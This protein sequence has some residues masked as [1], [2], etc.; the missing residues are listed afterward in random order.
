ML[1]FKKEYFQ[2]ET[3]RHLYPTTLNISKCEVYGCKE[4]EAFVYKIPNDR[5]ASNAGNIDFSLY[6]NGVWSDYT[7]I[8]IVEKLPYFQPSVNFNKLGD[9]TASN[10]NKLKDEIKKHIVD[11]ETAITESYVF[12]D[13]GSAGQNNLPYLPEGCVWFRDPIIKDVIALPISDLYGK[14]NQMV[15]EIRNAIKDL[16]NQDISDETKKLL[17]KLR[18]ETD[19]LLEELNQA[20]A[21]LPNR[22][23]AIEKDVADFK[24]ENET[25]HNELKDEIRT[26]RTENIPAE[27]LVD[28][29][30]SAKKLKTATDEDKIKLVNLSDEV[31]KAMA[32]N[33]P[34]SPTLEKDSV[35]REYIA[36]EAVN[37]SK[38][39]NS[40]YHTEYD[41]KKES[42]WNSLGFKL[43]NA[44][45]LN[46]SNVEFSFVTSYDETKNKPL[47]FSMSDNANIPSGIV[48]EKKIEKLQNWLFKYL[49][50]ANNVTH[51]GIITFGFGYDQPQK[52]NLSG[53]YY[54]FL[55]EVDGKPIEF[56]SAETPEVMNI[57]KVD[58]KAISYETLINEIYARPFSINDFSEREK[59]LLTGYS[60]L[61]NYK[62]IIKKFESFASFKKA[63]IMYDKILYPGVYRI[64]N[65]YKG[66]DKIRIYTLSNFNSKKIKEVIE[67]NSEN[68]LFLLK[69]TSFI[70]IQIIQNNTAGNH[71][72][73]SK[74]E[75]YTCKFI[76]TETIYDVEDILDM[77]NIG[78]YTCMFNI[79]CIEIYPLK[80]EA[81]ILKLNKKILKLN[82]T[83]GK[84][85]ARN[86]STTPNKNLEEVYNI[87]DIKTVEF[88]ENLEILATSNTLIKNNKI[89]YKPYQAIDE[90]KIKLKFKLSVIESK[91]ILKN[92]DGEFTD[93]TFVVDFSKKE[94]GLT[95]K[96]ND[97]K[98]EKLV[99]ISGINF[100]TIDTYM[101]DFYRTGLFMCIN[102]Y[103]LKSG[104]QFEHKVPRLR[105]H[106][107]IGIEIGDGKIELSNIRFLT[108][109]NQGT[110]AIFIGDSITEGLG[111]KTTDISKRWCSLLR[112]SYFNGNALCCGI[113]NGTTNNVKQVLDNIEYYC[114]YIKYYFVMI[115]TN[116]RSTG[117]VT[118]W[119]TQ[120]VEIYNKIK[121]FGGIPII[122]VPPLARADSE[123]ILQMRD[124]ILENG[125]DTIRM[126]IATSTGDG[127]TFDTSLST[128][129]VH[130]NVNGN[131]KMYERALIDLKKFM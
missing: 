74:G 101:V 7:A 55:L 29:S 16:I 131:Q 70:A 66:T 79:E 60:N 95:A 76:D 33:T 13:S 84:T 62:S 103:N 36:D 78:K 121:E 14:F 81:E 107:G 110:K 71:S 94:V 82:E 115:G 24:T 26:A 119:K 50:Y 128:D 86:I 61:N 111:M 59:F 67:L 123:Y 1:E 51:S 64:T 87:D 122:I 31:K 43:S 77:T 45:K 130:F 105:L 85:N 118:S 90:W 48:F 25:Q 89:F 129:G 120:I 99:D 11:L 104:E 83:L 112:D 113:G 102:I 97:W 63:I 37:A 91:L 10:L 49:F 56:T 108:A 4:R 28:N 30:L 106:G 125:W 6:P 46:N 35:V 8:K 92:E 18:T 20:S 116:Q 75:K 109:L 68:D 9:I 124:F 27:R 117:G 88:N 34:V 17:E 100:N 22:V 12:I 15:E 65:S 38:L 21:G 42:A 53:K 52:T 44:L 58:R 47:G 40:I 54:D 23:K 127:I 2:T 57:T 80:N 19:K 73:G 72:I 114:N 39:D 126:D 98:Y 41:V 32:G 69:E 3:N 96:L 93:G 5:Y